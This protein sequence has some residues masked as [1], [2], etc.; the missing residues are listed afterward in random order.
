MEGYHL[1]EAL[2]LNTT[3]TVYDAIAAPVLAPELRK[4]RPQFDF[5]FVA[6]AKSNT[7]YKL[8]LPGQPDV[9]QGLV[10]F[11]QAPG[12]LDCANMETAAFNK[13]GRPLYSGIGRAIVALCC[14]ISFDIGQ[15][16]FIRF[17]AKTRLFPYYERLGAHRIGGLLMV[18]DEAA[19]RRLVERFF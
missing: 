12:F 8:H 3:G 19:A 4:H 17:E 5:D 11:R 15:D 14:K 18:M 2:K 1:R 16:G 6:L 13:H 9:I 7:V 10:A